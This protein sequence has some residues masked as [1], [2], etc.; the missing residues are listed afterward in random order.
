MLSKTEPNKSNCDVHSVQSPLLFRNSG[1]TML[2][3]IKSKSQAKIS[4]YCGVFASLYSAMSPNVLPKVCHQKSCRP[5]AR[6]IF[7]NGVEQPEAHL[8]SHDTVCVRMWSVIL[9]YHL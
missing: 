1:T 8:K 3:N 6:G 9:H 7:P 4:R 2:R 5:A